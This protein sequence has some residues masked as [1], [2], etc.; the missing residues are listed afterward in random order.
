LRALGRIAACGDVHVMA[1]ARGQIEQSCVEISMEAKQAYCRMVPVQVDGCR[2]IWT[3]PAEMGAFV[4]RG[5]QVESRPFRI[6]SNERQWQ[7]SYYPH[8]QW[9]TS[10][11][12]AL[13]LTS[14]QDGIYTCTFNVDNASA[15]YTARFQPDVALGFC[16]V[17]SLHPVN[18]VTCL[19]ITLQARDN[20]ETCPNLQIVV[21]GDTAT[22]ALPATIQHLSAGKHAI[23]SAWFAFENQL[24]EFRIHY[25]PKGDEDSDVGWSALYLHCTYTKYCTY[26]VAMANC[27]RTQTGFLQPE[28][29]CGWQRF[30]PVLDADAEISVSLYV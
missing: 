16:N 17:R 21:D 26:Q 20:P 15:C 14:M 11:Q 10:G 29:R 3:L 19:A 1:V 30:A 13:Y 8:G 7:M 27:V 25:W 6:R 5:V 4:P 18:G 23:L 12:R 2:A 28:E 24:G 22:W 9:G